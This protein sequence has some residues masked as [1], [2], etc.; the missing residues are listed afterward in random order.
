VEALRGL[1]IL[2]DRDQWGYLM[3]IFSKPILDRP[4]I[5]TEIIQRKRARG[6]G[7]GNIRALFEALEREQ[8][9]RGNL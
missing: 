2:A 7:G 9:L 5:F 3:Q 8:A 4:T 6:F 1:N